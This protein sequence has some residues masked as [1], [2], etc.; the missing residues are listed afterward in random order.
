MQ[1]VKWGILGAAKFARE[2]MAPAI[3]AARGA[4]LYA[5]ATSDPAKAAGFQEFCPGLKLHASYDALLRIDRKRAE[6]SFPAIFAPDAVPMDFG[7][8]TDEDED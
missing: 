1:S 5:L 8:G 2:Q 6:A 3:H 7:D 4:E